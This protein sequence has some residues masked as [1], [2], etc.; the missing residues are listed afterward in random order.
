MKFTVTVTYPPVNN[1]KP[2]RVACIP[3]H[4][5]EISIHMCC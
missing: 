3:I 1:S 4:T 2:T 5:E